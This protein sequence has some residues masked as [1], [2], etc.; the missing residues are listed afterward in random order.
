MNTVSNGCEL[1]VAM[2]QNRIDR[3]I[4]EVNFSSGFVGLDGR[5][6]FEG[7]D[8]KLYQAYAIGITFDSRLLLFYIRKPLGWT[9]VC[10]EQVPEKYDTAHVHT[11]AIDIDLQTQ[12]NQV[13]SSQHLNFFDTIHESQ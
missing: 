1:A 3:F 4:E 12:Y 7:E 10:T 6:I 11:S 2:L 8:T 5:L 9:V 13:C